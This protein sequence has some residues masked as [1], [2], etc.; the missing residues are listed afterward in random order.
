MNFKEVGMVWKFGKKGTDEFLYVTGYQ[1]LKNFKK[2]TL[3]G[4]TRLG[5]TCSDGIRRLC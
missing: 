4:E 3:T 1:H 2:L 5:E